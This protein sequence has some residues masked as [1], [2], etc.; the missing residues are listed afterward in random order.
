[1]AVTLYAVD[2]LFPTPH[3]LE[4]CLPIE[5]RSIDSFVVGKKL[6]SLLWL[7]LFSTVFEEM[8]Y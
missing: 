1:M 2:R 3:S 8:H 7:L 6:D 5:I 4:F